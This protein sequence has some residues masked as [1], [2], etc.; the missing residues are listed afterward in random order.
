MGQADLLRLWN[1]EG[2][3]QV[4]HHYKSMIDPAL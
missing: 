2:M 1:A 3:I 4:R